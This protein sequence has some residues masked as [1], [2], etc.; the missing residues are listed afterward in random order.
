MEDLGH[1][2][3]LRPSGQSP[4]PGHEPWV[5]RGSGGFGFDFIWVGFFFFICLVCL[6]WVC[7]F[8]GGFLG[9]KG[10][11]VVCFCL[12]GLGFFVWYLFVCFGF[13]FG[14]LFFP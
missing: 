3:C 8:L 2:G 12:V 14:F 5:R 1:S 6:G 9:G 13:W 11:C 4:L 7:L 10:V